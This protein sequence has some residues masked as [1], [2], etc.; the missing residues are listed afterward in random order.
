MR[1]H[2]CILSV[3]IL[4]TFSVMDRSALFFLSHA[5]ELLSWWRVMM[6]MEYMWS[7]RQHILLSNLS[8]SFCINVV[9][10]FRL[11]AD[12]GLN[13]PCHL[14]SGVHGAHFFLKEKEKDIWNTYLCD[15]THTHI[16]TVWSQKPL[17]VDG[18]G[19]SQEALVHVVIS[20]L[21][22]WWFWMHFLLRDWRTHMFSSDSLSC[23]LFTQWS[24]S[25]FFGCSHNFMLYRRNRRI[26]SKL[27][28]RNA[29]FLPMI[30]HVC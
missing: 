29:A 6:S 3:S 13:D 24:S 19:F 15:H 10:D 7:W 30:W 16:S 14:W 28:L 2:H 9:N 4:L 27:S 18:K 20:A 12:T 21:D 17:H 8:R 11:D 5:F 23:P 22:S 25:R 1:A 26:P